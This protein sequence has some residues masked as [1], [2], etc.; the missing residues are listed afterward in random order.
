MIRLSRLGR[1]SV[2]S[3]SCPQLRKRSTWT[4]LLHW[5]GHVTNHVSLSS[6]E[7]PQRF[8]NDYRTM[9]WSDGT[10]SGVRS[11][12]PDDMFNVCRAERHPCVSRL[13]GRR[14][15]HAGVSLSVLFLTVKSLAA[16][17]RLSLQA[18]LTD[19]GR[20]GGERSELSTPR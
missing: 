8:Y 20:T 9:T 11:V 6:P 16:G 12:I 19:C 18:S 10:L 2:C 14:R 13:R 1:H 15:E 17:P 7:K 3:T 4:H 5:S